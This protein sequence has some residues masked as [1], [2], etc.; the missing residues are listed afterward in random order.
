MMTLQAFRNI[1]DMIATGEGRRSKRG[2]K[3]AM[4]VA[5]A[6][7]LLNATAGLGHAVEI[8]TQQFEM[9][10]IG[11][12]IALADERFANLENRDRIMEHLAALKN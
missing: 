11:E 2:S 7:A 8:N 4:V 3:R 1:H 5:G 6:I 9:P 10:E 12:E